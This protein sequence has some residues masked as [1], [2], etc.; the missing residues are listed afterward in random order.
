MS[1]N[2]WH[3]LANGIVGG[4]FGDYI[5]ADNKSEAIQEFERQHGVIP[6]IVKRCRRE[7]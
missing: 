3:C 5:W 1:R 4:L 6:H 7:W 2:L